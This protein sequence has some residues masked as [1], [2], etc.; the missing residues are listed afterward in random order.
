MR[1]AARTVLLREIARLEDRARF[2]GNHACELDAEA[3][4]LRKNIDVDLRAASE[5][6]AVVESLRDA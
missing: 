6:R 5:M 3:L 4:E 2:D 1:A